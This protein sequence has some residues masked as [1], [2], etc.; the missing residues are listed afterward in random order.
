MF[1]QNYDNYFRILETVFMEKVENVDFQKLEISM[2]Q[3]TVK[4]NLGE[5]VLEEFLKK[6]ILIIAAL[7]L[8]LSPFTVTEDTPVSKIHYLFVIL[9][10]LQI[11]V[12]SRGQITGVITR[13]HFLDMN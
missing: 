3:F 13:K 2:N 12:T 9:G 7:E 1:P 11:Y 8:E 6:K 5:P 4:G 10:V